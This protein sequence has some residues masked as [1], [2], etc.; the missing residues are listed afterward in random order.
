MK[1]GIGRVGVGLLILG[2]AA[3]SGCGG[4]GTSG[5][6]GQG[7]VVPAYFYPGPGSPWSDL[8][9]A[10]QTVPLI[11]IANADNGPGAAVD[12]NYTSA[13]NGLRAAGGSVIGYVYTS[14]GA[15]PIADVKA[16]IDQWL[17]LYTID[18][19]FVDE[20]TDDA[21]PGH[22]SYYGEIYNY[23]KSKQSI[24]VVVGNP[25]TNTLEAYL[26]QPTADKLVIFEGDYLSYTAFTPASWITRHASTDFVAI[27]YNVPDVTTM[28]H[29]LDQATQQHTGEVFITNDAGANPYDTLPPYWVN[30]YTA[31]Q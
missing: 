21:A 17:A 30:E 9:N 14:Y 18:G 16:D 27:V 8:N 22:L 31:L 3:L 29:C 7:L 4:G 19:I 1:V 13:I 11:A 23:V 15:R 6:G 28:Q 10:A 24:Y 20:M 26:T 5:G 12:P 25:G 2:L